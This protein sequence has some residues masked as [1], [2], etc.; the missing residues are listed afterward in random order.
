[1]SISIFHSVK[2]NPTKTDRAIDICAS[3]SAVFRSHNPTVFLELSNVQQGNLESRTL[4][5]IYIYLPFNTGLK[6]KI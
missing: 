1:M 3:E 6:T 5:A 2:K 4:T